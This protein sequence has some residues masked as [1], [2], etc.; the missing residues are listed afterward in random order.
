MSK[1]P[2]RKAAGKAPRPRKKPPAVENRRPLKTRGA[3]WAASLA[4]ALGRARVS[5]DM[6]SAASVV[7]AVFT[8][9]TIVS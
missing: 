8:L 3:A 5:P 4:D 1:S 2:R 6:I 7:I 9:L